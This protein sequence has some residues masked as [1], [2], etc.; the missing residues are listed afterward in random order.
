MRTIQ[1]KH[2]SRKILLTNRKK[3]R[4]PLRMKIPLMLLRWMIRKKTRMKVLLMMIP[5][6]TS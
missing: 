3:P 5:T 6:K 2:L 1:K 4:F